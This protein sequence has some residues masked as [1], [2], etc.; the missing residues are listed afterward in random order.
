M[1]SKYKYM[2]ALRKA[3]YYEYFYAGR[4]LRIGAWRHALIPRTQFQVAPRSAS[5]FCGRDHCHC[6]AA[7][8]AKSQPS[9]SHCA[10]G[11][12]RVVE[13]VLH[14]RVGVSIII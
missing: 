11:A 9:Q 4:A 5:V 13:R 7:S 6:A 2:H 8:D 14:A 3:K 10:L 1:A 12:R